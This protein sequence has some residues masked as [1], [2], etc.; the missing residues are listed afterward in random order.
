MKR[1]VRT[2][3]SGAVLV[4][5]L[6]ALALG[7][8]GSSQPGAAADTSRAVAASAVS[9]ITELGRSVPLSV[10]S[11]AAMRAAGNE[12]PAS[13]VMIPSSCT[14]T[15]TSATATGT[16]QGGFVPA[17]YQRYGDVIDLYVF[18]RP[19]AGEPDGIQLADEPFTRQAPFVYGG[20]RRWTVTV[21]LDKQLLSF[22]RPARCMA[23]AQ[24]TMDFQGAP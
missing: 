4:S 23:A 19:M 7:C 24:P 2:I 8:G 12:G 13:S 10:Q 16:Y 3:S 1:R 5:V 21:P 22:G 15:A 18:T 6:S 20:G 17:V 9:A 14:V 11:D